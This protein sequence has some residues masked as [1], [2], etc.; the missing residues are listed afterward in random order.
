MDLAGTAYR[1]LELGQ[2]WGV[3]DERMSYDRGGIGRE[4]HLHL[5]R[6]G[7]IK[8]VGYT[9]SGAPSSGD[10]TN[11]RTEAA[12]RLR[13]RLNPK[14]SPDWR[15]PF[16]PQVPYSIPPGDYWPRLRDELSKLTYH[17]VGMQ[18][19]LLSKEDHCKILGHSPDSSDAFTQAHAFT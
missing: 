3:P 10:Y 19:A 4:M 12:F 15:Q 1:Y 14:G 13:N 6:F 11:L 8:A 2:K 9:G 18:T 17:L 7:I 5:S 16:L